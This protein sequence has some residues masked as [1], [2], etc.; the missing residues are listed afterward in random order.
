MKVKKK[1]P[2]RSLGQFLIMVGVFVFAGL[3]LLLNVWLPI[4]SQRA[5][6]Q[7]KRWEKQ[8]SQDKS[9]LQVLNSNYRERTSLAFLDRW[10]RAH[11]PWK[12]PNKKDI[13]IFYE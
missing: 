1:R 7:L 6:T 10:A 2:H 4:Q 5:L 8:L 13:F 12:V 11:G 9:Q 3:V